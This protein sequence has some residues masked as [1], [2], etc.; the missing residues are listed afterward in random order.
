MALAEAP[1]EDQD[2]ALSEVAFPD[3]A[4]STET[5]PEEALPDET[6][7][8][9]TLPV[10][11]L[12]E[13][14]HTEE[15][16]TAGTRTEEAPAEGAPLLE[17]VAPEMAPPEEAPAEPAPPD[18]LQPE[19]AP[20]EAAPPDEP[21]PEAAPAEVPALEWVAPEVPAT[22]PATPEEAPAEPVLL[23]ETPPEPA[24]PELQ[25]E[26]PGDTVSGMPADGTVETPPPPLL[27]EPFHTIDYFA[28]LGIRMVQDENPSDPLGKQLKS[29]TDWLKVMRRLPQKD[30]EMIPDIAAERS[31]QAIAAHSIEGNEVITETM[32]DVLA[33]QGMPERASEMYR[34][35]SLLN[36]GKMAYFA[37]KIEQLNRS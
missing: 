11:A 5:L 6:L 15:A 27:F 29:F 23:K 33:K 12:A 31:I 7:P 35:L 26:T 8:D 14:I 17:G 37:A 36:P 20:A 24:P 9:E 4:S 25:S 22:E 16:P 1:V 10:E 3:E 32:A 34:K 13:V 28:S 30:R 18:E 2:P 19:A 21:Q